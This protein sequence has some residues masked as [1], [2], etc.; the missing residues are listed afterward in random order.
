MELSAPRANMRCERDNS[1][2][3]MVPQ[4]RESQNASW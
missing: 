1:Q 3:W 2:V 4:E